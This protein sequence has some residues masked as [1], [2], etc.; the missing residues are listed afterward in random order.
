V[1]LWGVS[2]MFVVSLVE[3]PGNPNPNFAH[4]SAA[5]PAFFLAFGLPIALCLRSLR[6]TGFRWWRV[7]YAWAA[8]GLVLLAL[9]NINFYVNIYPTQVPSDA[10]TYGT[11]GRYLQS[12]RP[13]TLAYFVGR[14]AQGLNVEIASMMGPNA[15]AGQLF[16]PS[17]QLPLP[18]T[19]DKNLDFVFFG[20][21][22]IYLPI[23]QEY[24]PQGYVEKLTAPPGKVAL[25]T[26]Y[27]VTAKQAMSRFGVMA[28]FTQDKSGGQVLW[29]GTVPAVGAT[30]SDATLTYPLTAKW[31]GALYLPT[32]EQVELTLPGLDNARLWVMGEPQALGSSLDLDAGWVPFS[33]EAHLSSG[34]KSSELLLQEGQSGSDSFVPRKVDQ[35]RLWPKA[36]NN[37]LALT[38][39]GGG[40]SVHRIDPFIGSALSGAYAYYRPGTLTQTE[41]GRYFASLNLAL[42]GKNPPVGTGVLRWAGSLLSDN[43]R[44]TMELHTTA[45]A[46]LS[47][48]GAVVLTRCDKKENG[49][50]SPIL[51]LSAGWHSIQ[52]D[53]E[54]STGDKG[55]ELLWTRLNGT[56]E[57]V[58]PSRLRYADSSPPDGVVSWPSTPQTIVCGP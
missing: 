41:A 1:L 23:I 50:S 7:A 42:P 55:L 24:Y 2:V 5:Y 6:L 9:A 53:F 56:R 20:D 26:V 43:D 14:S 47:I 46:Q 8:I 32:P 30:P 10:Y 37:G 3:V 25:E 13:D 44:Y 17:R 19:P 40:K 12:L 51:K 4:W 11:Q 58:P 38:L 27:H 35:G 39:I 36:P 21:T 34:D 48:D 57:L 45:H 31:S 49:P 22:L 16:N 29:Q 18:G 52:I 15:A 28:V 33:V 54:P